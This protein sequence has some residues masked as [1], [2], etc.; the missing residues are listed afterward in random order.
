MSWQFPK[1]THPH[2]GQVTLKHSFQ[3]MHRWVSAKGEVPLVTP[4]GVRFVAHATIA[5]RGPHRGQRVIRFLQGGAERARVYECCWGKMTSCENSPRRP[6]LRGAGP[7]DGERRVALFRH[8]WNEWYELKRQ[9]VPFVQFVAMRCSPSP[10][11]DAPPV[12]PQ[13][14]ARCCPPAHSR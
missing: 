6:L 12:A 2:E 10:P 7:G 13:S 11:S 5:L 8:E 4:A 3:E 14:A 1:A 9:F